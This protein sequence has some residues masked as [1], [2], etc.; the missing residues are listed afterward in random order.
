MQ[1]TDAT[2]RPSRGDTVTVQSR[3]FNPVIEYEVV[4]LEGDYVVLAGEYKIPIEKAELSGGDTSKEGNPYENYP[5]GERVTHYCHE[6]DS[7]QKGTTLYK[8][9]IGWECEECESQKQM[10]TQKELEDYDKPE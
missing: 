5:E 3:F 6:C 8:C 7:E 1:M 2:Q 10:Y 4:R 9:G